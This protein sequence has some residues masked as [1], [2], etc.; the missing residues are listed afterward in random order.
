MGHFTNPCCRSLR[1]IYMPPDCDIYP[2]SNWKPKKAD[3]LAA[4][5]LA[6]TGATSGQHPWADPAATGGRQCTGLPQNGD[7]DDHPGRRPQVRL[8]AAGIPGTVSIHQRRRASYR[9]ASLDNLKG[10]KF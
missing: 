3:L 4:C 2:L 7:G 6:T 10:S 1:S 9:G 5:E 8:P